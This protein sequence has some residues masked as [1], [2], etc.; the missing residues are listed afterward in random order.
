M[1]HAPGLMQG[2]SQSIEEAAKEQTHAFSCGM[3]WA[4]SFGVRASAVVQ[5]G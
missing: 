5:V 2:E 4:G 3:Y 1:V